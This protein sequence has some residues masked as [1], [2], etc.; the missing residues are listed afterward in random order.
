[1]GNLWPL[2]LGAFCRDEVALKRAKE[3]ENY[4]LPEFTTITTSFRE[5]APPNFQ[6]LQS[7]LIEIIIWAGLTSCK[8]H[9]RNSVKTSLITNYWILHERMRI[10]VRLL[11]LD[12]MWDCSRIDKDFSTK[13]AQNKWQKWSKHTWIQSP[14]FHANDE[15]CPNNTTLPSLNYVLMFA[16]RF[17]HTK[18][19][20]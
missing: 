2:F 10:K 14:K 6:I 11:G 13:H 8:V 19:G 5:L 9:G 16:Q 18:C 20:K 4:S 12:C 17:G 7:F 15:G 3:A 1:M